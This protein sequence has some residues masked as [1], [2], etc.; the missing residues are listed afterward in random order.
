MEESNSVGSSKNF[1]VRFFWSLLVLA[2]LGWIA[3]C[4][5]CSRDFE[6]R[7]RWPL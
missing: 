7:S 2:V 3:D 5:K 4:Q 1:I 6:I